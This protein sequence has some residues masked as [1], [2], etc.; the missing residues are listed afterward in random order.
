MCLLAKEVG[1]KRPPGFE[2]LRLRKVRATELLQPRQDSKDIFLISLI[3][4][5]Q[6]SPKGDLLCSSGVLRLPVS[7]E[8]PTKY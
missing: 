1:C 7:Y 2:S 5:E 4:K 3:K 6:A 8:A